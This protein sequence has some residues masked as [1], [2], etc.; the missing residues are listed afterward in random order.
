MMRHP[1]AESSSMTSDPAMADLVRRA[2]SLTEPGGRAI[3][4]LVGAPGSGKSTLTRHLADALG[5]ERVALA[6]MDGFHLANAE[7][8]RLGL[9]DVKGAIETFDAAGYAALIGRI[10]AGFGRETVYA[11]AFDRDLEEPI[12]G[13]ILIGPD[14]PLVITE[15]NYLLVDAGAWAVAARQ[16]RQAWYLDVDD[17]LRRTRLIARHRQFGK[18]D[19][20][21]RR[22]AL[23]PDE[24]NA[25][26]I[27]AT[28]VR[29]DL[30]VRLAD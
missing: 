29:A 8:V 7:L 27:A 16:F 10:A 19:A 24:A 26:M 9:R 21:A 13:S 18:T 15:G 17:E 12:A 1:L 30:R 28:A 4:A 23:G 3:L 20:E 11:P 25:A 22:W 5:P 2:A 14:V 6:P